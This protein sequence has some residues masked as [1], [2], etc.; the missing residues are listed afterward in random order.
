VEDLIGKTIKEIY[1]DKEMESSI[2][3]ITD[4]NKINYYLEAD[5]CSTSYIDSF[6]GINNLLNQKVISMKE[7]EQTEEVI[8]EWQYIRT[9]PVEIITEKG[10]ALFTYKNN[11]NGYYNGWIKLTD[12]PPKELIPITQDID[13]AAI[14]TKETQND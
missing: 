6:K 4:E 1:F 9:H 5:C 8:A 11:S 14:K 2:V 10:K 7:L 3:F 12:N 13:V